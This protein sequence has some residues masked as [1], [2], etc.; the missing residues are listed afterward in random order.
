MKLRAAALALGV[1]AVAA[2]AARAQESVAPSP[3]P[4]AA[5]AAYDPAALPSGPVG[6]A[7]RLGREIVMNTPQTMP[8]YVRSN[9]SCSACHIEGGTKVRGGSFLGTYAR[10]PQW[11]K[12]AKR[13][14]TLQDRLAECFLYSMNGR[15]PAYASKEMIGLVAYIAWLSRGVPTLS[16]PSPQD[17]FIEP[18]PPAPPDV[19]HGAKLYA[20]HCALCHQPSGAGVTG[21]FPPLWGPSSFNDLAGMAHLDRMTGFVHYNMPQ[22]APGSLT[23]REAYDVA[24]FVLSHPRPKFDP[25]ALVQSSPLPAGFF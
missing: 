8:G 5:V 21:V 9:M 10:F 16:T 19:R 6:E 22:G 2:L 13:V 17:R 20:Q 23:L 7:I 1:V 3:A 14:I 25:A 24:A 15:P 4:S 18:L 12:R 11:N